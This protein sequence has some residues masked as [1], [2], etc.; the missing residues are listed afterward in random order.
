[1]NYEDTT[2]QCNGTESF[3]KDPKD[4]HYFYYCPPAEAQDD[5]DNA[6]DDS[7]TV[8]NKNNIT[9]V[10]FECPQGYG[11]H[12]QWR[13]CVPENLVKNCSLVFCPTYIY[14]GVIPDPK[15]CTAYYRCTYGFPSR[16]KCRK[17]TVFNPESGVCE[18]YNQQELPD[19]L[20]S[21]KLHF[22]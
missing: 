3:F 12:E 19:C 22:L 16:Y 15:D 21:K 2:I 11:Y 14:D 17:E 13:N 7:S 8:I 4:C 1:M 6:D 5:G 9:A 18:K 20:K 10:H